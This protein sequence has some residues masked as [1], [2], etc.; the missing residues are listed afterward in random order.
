MGKPLQPN[1]LI[2]DASSSLDRHQARPFS[3]SNLA[4]DPPST[5][6]GCPIS[7]NMASN[8]T[9]ASKV[10][11]VLLFSVLRHSLIDMLQHPR[12]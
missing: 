7:K 3:A 2:H 10:I 5:E 1:G 8:R 4:L 12:P 6:L 11:R 9:M